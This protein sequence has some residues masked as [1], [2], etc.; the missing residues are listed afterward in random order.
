MTY[1]WRNQTEHRKGTLP[2]RS[3]HFIGHVAHEDQSSLK[4]GEDNNPEKELN[5]ERRGKNIKT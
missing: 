4:E 1:L 3:H 2:V 5:G